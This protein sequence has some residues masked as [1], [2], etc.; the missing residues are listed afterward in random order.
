[1]K[2]IEDVSSVSKA[3]WLN[4]LPDLQRKKVLKIGTDS[5]DIIKIIS[6][7]NLASLSC[8]GVPQVELKDIVNKFYLN[9]ENIGEKFDVVIF[10]EVMSIDPVNNISDFLYKIKGLLNETGVLLVCCPDGWR[11][12]KYRYFI[13]KVLQIK[14]KGFVK[15]FI[16]NPSSAAPYS[17]IPYIN[18]KIWLTYNYPNIEEETYNKKIAFKESIK[19]YIFRI[20]GMY[21]PLS[22]LIIVLNN[23][24]ITENIHEKKQINNANEYINDGTKEMDPL[25]KICIAYRYTNKHYLFSYGQHDKKLRSMKKIEFNP[26]ES[27]NDLER[28]YKNL[29][30]FKEHIEIFGNNGIEIP[31]SVYF[32]ELSDRHESSMTVVKGM[33]L[34]YLVDKNM[35]QKN[36]KDVIDLLNKATDMQICFQKLTENNLKEVI[37]DLDPEYFLNY[38]GLDFGDINIEGGCI[39]HCDLAANNIHLDIEANRWGIIDWEGLT[40]GMPAMLD[41]FS[42]FTSFR[43]TIGN[44]KYKDFKEKYYDA[45]IDTYFSSNWISKCILINLKKYCLAYKIPEKNIYGYFVLFL[46]F[47]SNKF[48]IYKVHDY[49]LLFEDMLRYTVE[50]K[51][52]FIVYNQ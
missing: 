17:I 20:I 15:Y 49:Q 42:M 38:L 8:I 41:L 44:K 3:N 26:Y 43:F 28:E 48:R 35:C 22:G 10:D 31:L 37:Y 1:M 9:E 46:M 7:S 5:T 6:Y 13:R 45:I 47:Q 30:L 2:K 39:Q 32:N 23:V 50:N 33:S 12:L 25:V 29:L 51:H 18:D 27:G 40:Q 4:L 21:N 16:C 11:N 34:K 36:N 52:K 24:D 19:K 14:S